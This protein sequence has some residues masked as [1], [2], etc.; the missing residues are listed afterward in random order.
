[1]WERSVFQSDQEAKRSRKKV[2]RNT[3]IEVKFRAGPGDEEVSADYFAKNSAEK[4]TINI[5]ILQLETSIDSTIQPLSDQTDN[6][7]LHSFI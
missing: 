1:M 4:K 3:K 5:K 6:F 7:F 2:K